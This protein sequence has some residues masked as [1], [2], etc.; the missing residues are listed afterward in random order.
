MNC[1][2]DGDAAEHEDA[3][4]DALADAAEVEQRGERPGAGEGRAEHL[5]A[6]QN[7]GAD[8]GDD[9]EPDDAAAGEPWQISFENGRNLYESGRRIKPA[10]ARSF[11]GRGAA[12][13]I[14][15]MAPRPRSGQSWL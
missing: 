3:V 10:T 12:A 11:R 15:R 8:H 4:E 2:H 5:G 13:L 14:L 7:G 9:V 1:D 6:D